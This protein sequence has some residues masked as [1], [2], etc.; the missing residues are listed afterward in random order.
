[1]LLALEDFLLEGSVV[2][3]SW[4]EMPFSCAL[5]GLWRGRSEKRSWPFGTF[6]AV[7][8]RGD[9]LWKLKS[10]MEMHSFTKSMRTYLQ[11]CCSPLRRP[12]GQTTAP[13]GFVSD[14]SMSHPTAVE[15]SHGDWCCF[16]FKI[17]DFTGVL[18]AACSHSAFPS[19]VSPLC[20]MVPL[21]D[22]SPR[23]HQRS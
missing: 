13:S 1:M 11:R 19:H 14:R 3:L 8:C 15:N 9:C 12:L 17:V 20:L 23:R 21:E 10:W 18:Q 22:T 16:K 6:S 2:R 4:A 5:G 7:S